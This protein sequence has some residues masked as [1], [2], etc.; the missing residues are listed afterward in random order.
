LRI[1]NI[2]YLRG[3]AAFLVVAAH[4]V[5]SSLRNAPWS[6]QSLTSLSNF[7][8]IG[9][10][11]FFVISGFVMPLS[12]MGKR[13]IKDSSIFMS[14]RWLRI[15]P[16]YFIASTLV[17]LYGLFRG[18]TPSIE[19][20]IS[21]FTF[22]P[23]GDHDV[24]VNPI[25]PVGWTLSYEFFFYFIIAVAL[26]FW[27]KRYLAISVAFLGA[28]V[29]VGATIHLDSFLW[30]WISNPIVLEFAMGTAVF[31]L[32]RSGVLSRFGRV[33]V[34]GFFVSVIVL[35]TE[36]VVG[37]GSI[38]AV[39]AS[40][41]TNVVLYRV[42]LW[43]VPSALIFSACVGYHKSGTDV[44]YF[45]WLHR[46][47]TISFST[48]LAHAPVSWVAGSFFLQFGLPPVFVFLLCVLVGHASGFVLYHLVEKP[49]TTYF[50]RRFKQKT[51]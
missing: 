7:G 27:P 4:A 6:G 2:V 18:K 38:D 19:S 46:L 23:F 48:Y 11:I 37:F 40:A 9:V 43:G 15:A 25:L 39:A 36:C 51:A 24:L 50:S 31:A 21:T 32:W 29:L 1:T 45:K 28:L 12:L 30:R 33:L 42:L 14:R 5:D 16:T 26:T 3:I 34:V 22:F 49:V 20:L 13:G 8:A 10:D 47:G 41:P 44:W 35:I 17:I